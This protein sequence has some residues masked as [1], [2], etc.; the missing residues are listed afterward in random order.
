MLF[1]LLMISIFLLAPSLAYGHNNPG[2]SHDSNVKTYNQR[3]MTNLTD[4][5]RISDLSIPGTH[6]T[7]AFYGGDA[8]QTQSMPLANQ[9]DSGIRVLDIRCRRSSNA[10][11]IY[12]GI[13]YQRASFDDVLKTVTDFLKRNPG[14]AVLMRVQEEGDP[15]SSSRSFEDVF[16]D[17]W[18]RYKD[19]FWAPTSANSD[20]PALM[21]I[22]R[23]IVV[24]QNFTGAKQ[25]Y[26]VS[27]K[28]FNTQDDYTLGSN[29]DLYDKWT[30][31][32][33]QLR[34]ADQAAYSGTSA[35]KYMNYLSGSGGSFP[36]FVASGHSSP[37]TSAP[38]LATGRTTP[39]W[40]NSWP[41]F[42][43][44]DCFIGICTIAFEGTNVLTY[45]RL[46]SEFRTRVGILMADFPGPG[47]IERTIRLNDW[48]VI[49]R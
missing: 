33:N 46:G 23:K 11:L 45:E 25:K 7:M 38:R 42:P 36:Y 44:V 12:H 41:D 40:K 15:V 39:G 20:N 21:D 30:K 32:K 34:N 1:R 4:V 49:R 9:L 29:W 6:D 2:Y 31:V 16:R 17:Y 35:T 10:L 8:A 13:V 48:L 5:A 18:E 22:R 14:E 28:S 3:W 26:G 47:L 37:G 19:F 24:L 43:R 27:Y